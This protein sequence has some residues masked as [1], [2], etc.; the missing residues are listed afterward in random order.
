MNLVTV[1]VLKTFDHAGMRYPAGASITV[2][3][4]LAKQWAAEGHVKL[5]EN[6]A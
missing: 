3:E 5:S 2:G 1:V 4:A 6:K